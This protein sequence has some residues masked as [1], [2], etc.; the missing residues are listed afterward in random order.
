MA[1]MKFFNVL[2]VP[3]EGAIDGTYY[4][5]KGDKFEP[6]LVSGGTPY[7]QDSNLI[8][9]YVHSGNKEI[10]IDSIDVENGIFHSVNH[11]LTNGNR[12]GV[13]Y[14]GNN[15]GWLQ[16][17]IYAQLPFINSYDP[18][19]NGYIVTVIDNNSF[20][21][22]TTVKDDFDLSKFRL[23][24]ST[25]INQ[26]FTQLDGDNFDI[27]IQGAV[28]RA[29]RYVTTNGSSNYAYRDDGQ[30]SYTHWDTNNII[31]GGIIIS[32]VS[33][34][35]GVVVNRIMT[36][37]ALSQGKY[38]LIKRDK[39]HVYVGVFENISTIMLNGMSLVNGT[40]I[41]IYKK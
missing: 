35:I 32:V 24:L 4:V 14:I 37:V 27:H 20:T 23:E 13:T 18:N 28:F 26:N 34:N 5:K 1:S 15:S 16:Q 6:V 2:D 36:G 19:T 29:P 33:S 31:Q 3:V 40:T 41:K 10:Y 22:D 7:K 25:Q 21:L 9:E 30:I 38:Q 8:Y 39:S 12:V 11:G 17:D